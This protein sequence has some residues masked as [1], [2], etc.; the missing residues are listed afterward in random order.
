MNKKTY[1]STLNS[2]LKI[3]QNAW[4]ANNIV[5]SIVSEAN[6]DA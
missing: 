4:M 3:K 6:G 5:R 1:L 2:K